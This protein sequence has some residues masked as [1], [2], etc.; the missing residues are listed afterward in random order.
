MKKYSIKLSNE[1]KKDIKILKKAGD[2]QALNKL[3]ELMK[4]LKKDPRKGKGRPKHL[5]YFPGNVWRRKI[6]DKHRLVYEIFEN[7]VM[8]EVIQAF[9]HYKDK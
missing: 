1:A 2:K 4:E 9:G 5:K 7:I 3:K 8:V 6:T